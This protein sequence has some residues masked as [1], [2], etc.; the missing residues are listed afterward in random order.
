MPHPL[1]QTMVQWNSTNEVLSYEGGGCTPPQR[2]KT[3]KTLFVRL[4]RTSQTDALRTDSEFI[5]GTAA[6]WFCSVIGATSIHTSS[7]SEV[8][9]SLKRSSCWVVDFI[10]LGHF[11]LIFVLLPC[12]ELPALTHWDSRIWLASHA[13]T[14]HHDFSRWNAHQEPFNMFKVKNGYE[15]TWHLSLS[16]IYMLS[17]RGVTCMLCMQRPWGGWAHTKLW[18]TDPLV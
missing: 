9:L 17:L 16:V 8:S 3:W 1:T 5:P 7:V 15:Y 2:L 18:R 4:V 10:V 14:P 11:P 12:A 13:L 6:P